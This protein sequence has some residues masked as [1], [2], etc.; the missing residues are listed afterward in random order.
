MLELKEI[1]KTIRDKISMSNLAIKVNY[2]NYL[3]KE[4]EKYVVEEVDPNK[5]SEENKE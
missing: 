1:N 3:E 4:K 5:D 2:F